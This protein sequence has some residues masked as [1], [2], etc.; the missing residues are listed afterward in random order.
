MQDECEP[1]PTSKTVTEDL[2]AAPPPKSP[3][4]LEKDRTDDGSMTGVQ[5]QKM[6]ELEDE[7]ALCTIA[8]AA[9][10]GLG[11]QEMPDTFEHYVSCSTVPTDPKSQKRMSSFEMC[12]AP[13][14]TVRDLTPPQKMLALEKQYAPCSTVMDGLIPQKTS[15]VLEKHVPCSEEAELAASIQLTMPEEECALQA[16]VT[17][18]PKK[19]QLAIPRRTNS[20][21][22]LS[23]VV[24]AAQE[25]EELNNEE[26]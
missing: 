10:T 9:P 11:P 4:V 23:T 8:A 18:S 16:T 25:K 17:N 24:A 21:V 20:A 22:A 19:E 5:L 2:A 15:P 12:V 7:D 13:C 26:R 1:P 6:P 3:S 14:A